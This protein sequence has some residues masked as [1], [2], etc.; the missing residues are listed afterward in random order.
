MFIFQVSEDLKCRAGDV[1]QIVEHVNADWIKGRLNG[2]VGLIPKT[3]LQVQRDVRVLR[4]TK[5]KQKS[6]SLIL[7]RLTDCIQMDSSSSS[8]PPS[9][10]IEMN[11]EMTVIAD[12]PSMES[13][14]LSVT[15]GDK[16]IIM[17]EVRVDCDS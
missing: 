7:G 6:I 10:P 9:Q 2:R 12:Y 1:I 3:F 15:R 17:E 4:I 5:N 11:K 13:G 14:H 16:V 8:L